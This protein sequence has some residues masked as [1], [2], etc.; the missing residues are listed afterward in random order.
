MFI[1]HNGQM[2]FCIFLFMIMRAHD[3]YKEK[4]SGVK[5]YY[6]LP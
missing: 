3:G 5:F 2:L 1:S 6:Y 4:R